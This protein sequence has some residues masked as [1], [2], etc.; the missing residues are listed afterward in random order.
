[1]RDAKWYLDIEEKH[2]SREVHDVP[3]RIQDDT[4]RASGHH[5]LLHTAEPEHVK[6]HRRTTTT[7]DPTT[8][9]SS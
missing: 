2:K 7:R 6:E 5:N 1:M 8:Q 3:E 9:I 4:H